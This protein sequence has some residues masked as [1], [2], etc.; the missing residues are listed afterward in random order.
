M[1]FSCYS[2]YHIALHLNGQYDEAD[3]FFEKAIRTNGD[4]FSLKDNYVA[5]VS[6]D[7]LRG[8]Y[9]EATSFG[10][11]ILDSLGVSI[12]LEPEIGE[13]EDELRGIR[14]EFKRRGIGPISDLLN[15][16]Q[17]KHRE[18]EFMCELISA[19]VPP[20][21]FYNPMVSGLLIFTTIRLALKNGVFAAMGYPFSTSTAPFIMIE[22]NYKTGYE[23]AEFAI[24]ISGNNKRS[25]GNSK[26]LFILFA[27]HWLK[28]LKDNS[29]L[30]VA[31]E[32][33]HLLQQ[34]GDI[35]MAGFIYFNTIPYILERGDELAMVLEEIEK[36]LDFAYKTQN[37]HSL[38]T[39]L[40]YKQLVLTLMS[41]DGDVTTFSQNG[42]DEQVHMEE[43]E[44]N[45][46]SHCYY[47]IHK[48]MMLYI[49][50][51]VEMAYA[52]ALKAMALLPY[53]TGFIPVSTAYYYAALVFCRVLKKD[54][55]VLEELDGYIRQWETWASYCPENWLHKL[56]L[57]Q[58]ER[59]R[60]LGRFEEAVRF[61]GQAVGEAKRNR[62]TQD[63]ALC[64]ERFADFWFENGNTELGE[65]HIAKAHEFFSQWGGLRKVKDLEV[66]Y[67]NVFTSGE[68]RDYDLLN[69]IKAQNLLTRETRIETL[70]RQLLKILLE[71][72]GAEKVF[73]MRQKGKWRIE[74]FRDAQGNEN[75][76]QARAISDDL[77]SSDMVKYT[78]RTGKETSL[79]KFSRY[80]ND[81]YVRRFK[82]KSILVLPITSQSKLVAIIYLEHSQIE[83]LFTPDKL[84]AIRL[85]SSQIAISLVNAQIYDDLETLVQERTCELQA[86]K[87]MAEV[88]NR[89]KSAFLANMSHELR[90]PLSAVIGFSQLMDRR[91]ELSSEQRGFLEII[92]RSGEHLLKLINQVLE[93]SKIEADVTTIEAR[94]VDLRAQLTELGDMFRLKSMNTGL[95]F[96]LEMD[97]RSAGL[98]QGR[99][100]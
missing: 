26:H 36:G 66:N 45:V 15:I 52:N 99:R 47:Y 77:L 30:E 100:H 21:F 48:T 50:G 82:P 8:M 85:L 20:S 75:V 65:V 73:L 74:G 84:E 29:C 1:K 31:R 61:Y 17:Q 83:Y 57:I 56:R 60:A 55:S 63:I 37:S 11:S 2:E 95:D 5:K 10:L 81:N 32:A 87:E 23:Y 90:T 78:I 70:V 28:P 39:F 64:Y 18:M 35:Q 14:A 93:L 72:S 27:Y 6:Q 79:D 67:P 40:I 76:L 41:E 54:R 96:D 7:S 44:T 94:D 24:R 62:F 9:K 34:G 92:I 86:A 25:L 71:V 80:L 12:S 58:A 53:I 91:G 97:P 16:P 68:R 98:R 49:F 3:E 51:Y 89:A 4:I 69:I 22:N 33:F 43:Y 59:A 42:F 46:M 13:L 19:I 88:A 38:G